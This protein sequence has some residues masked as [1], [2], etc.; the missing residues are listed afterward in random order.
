MIYITESFIPTLIR[1]TLTNHCIELILFSFFFILSCGNIQE[2]SSD[3]VAEV[4]TKMSTILLDKVSAS[5]PALKLPQL[6]SVTPNSSGKGG[7]MQKRN[8]SASQ[9]NQIENFSERKSLDQP[10]AINQVENIP[11]GCCICPAPHFMPICKYK[12]VG[13]Y[14]GILFIN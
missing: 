10:L 3:D 13:F 8:T 11:Q 2:S 5:P 9:T 1:P 7:N 6:F 14:N 12:L 4:T